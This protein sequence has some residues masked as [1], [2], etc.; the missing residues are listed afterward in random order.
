MN[1]KYRMASKRKNLAAFTIII[2]VLTLL[3]TVSA[4]TEKAHGEHLPERN[5]RSTAGAIISFGIHAGILILLS[6]VSGFISRQNRYRNTTGTIPC[7]DHSCCPTKIDQFPM[8]WPMRLRIPGYRHSSTGSIGSMPA[9]VE[10]YI[11]DI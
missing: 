10:N 6:A 5:D 4:L 3:L 2:G 1:K 7:I 9:S 11:P 8:A